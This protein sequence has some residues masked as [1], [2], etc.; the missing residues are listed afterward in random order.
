[1]G[2]EGKECEESKKK[3]GIRKKIELREVGGVNGKKEWE[4]YCGS[5]NQASIF[6]QKK[7]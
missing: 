7:Y 5:F 4:W 1:M 2:E 6:P 3:R